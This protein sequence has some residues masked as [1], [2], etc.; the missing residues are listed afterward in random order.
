MKYKISVP[1]DKLKTI[2]RGDK[3][4]YFNVGLQS[5]PRAGFEIDANCPQN[6]KRFLIECIENG[7]IKP[8]AYMKE[9]EYVWEQ[10]GG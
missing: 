1:A 2:R 10:L 6:H 7:W 5:A 3:D 8:V 9:S 4:F